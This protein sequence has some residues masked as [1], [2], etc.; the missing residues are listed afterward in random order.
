MNSTKLRRTLKQGGHVFGCMLS[1]MASTRFGPVLEGSTLDYAVIDSEHSSRDRSE[2]QSLVA[3]LRQADITPIVRIPIPKSEWVAMALDAGT[4]GVLVP[5]CETV[6][7]VQACVATVKWHPL[8]GEYL[9]KAVRD[10][11][12]PSAAAKK[13]LQN[14]RKESFIIIGIESEPAYQNLDAIL[15]VGDIDGVFI[16]P[17]DMSTSLGVPDDYKNPK[18]LRVIKDI[19]TRCAARDVPVMVHQ[20]TIETSTKAINFGARFVLHS[21]DGRMLQ[22]IIQQEMNA[23]R[24]AAGAVVKRAVDTV[25]TV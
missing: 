23:L 9:A 17:N 11:K 20:Q 10:A 15:D 5:Y 3:M 22:R 1:Q 4:A 16:G 24:K 2:I 7:E 14:R 21:T 13:Y 19:I 25:E 8:K 12:L 18:Y 6:E